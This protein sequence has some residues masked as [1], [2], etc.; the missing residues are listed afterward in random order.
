MVKKEIRFSFEKQ[1]YSFIEGE[2]IDDGKKFLNKDKFKE[3]K[4]L[5]EAIVNKDG[6]K[7][8]SKDEY[9]LI[10]QLQTIFSNQGENQGVS[11]KI[12]DDADFE[13][14][15]TFKKGQDVEKFLKEK[16]KA[17]NLEWE[18]GKKIENNVG[19]NNATT[20]STSAEQ[21]ADTQ[22]VTPVSEKVLQ[23]TA[24]KQEKINK[25]IEA[26]QQKQQQSGNFKKYIESLIT[27]N[28]YNKEG[29]GFDTKHK[30]EKG[31]N[32]YNIAK[33]ALKKEAEAKGETTEP[34]KQ[35][36]NERIAQIVAANKGKIKDINNIQV[37]TEI[38]IGKSGTPTPSADKEEAVETP[39]VKTPVVG[40]EQVVVEQQEITETV[41][42]GNKPKADPSTEDWSVVA[43]YQGT[44]GVK[45]YTQ[46]KGTGEEAKTETKFVYEK[47]GIK[48]EGA[49]ETAV[50]AQA[51]K[52]NKALTA[53]ATA[54][55]SE[56]AEAKT[57]RIQEALATILE[58]GT[59]SAV[60]TGLTK[61][62]ENKA[63]VSKEYYQN[64][65]INML[66][67]GDPNLVE[68]MLGED[69]ETLETL[70]NDNPE[71]QKHIGSMIKELNQ[72]YENSTITL[73]EQKIRDVLKNN[74]ID[75]DGVTIAEQDAVTAQ[76]ATESAPAVEA[77]DKVF[78]KT[79]ITDNEG[80]SYYKATLG[81]EGDLKDVEFRA[82]D[83]KDLNDFL[84][85]LEKA[86]DDNA[87]TALFKE[88]AENCNDSDLL[89]CLA[90][91]ADKL[92]ADKADIK[93]LVENATLDTLYALNLPE[94]GEAK[95]DVQNVIKA[96][97]EAIQN[98][99][100]LRALP[101][102]AKYFDKISEVNIKDRKTELMKSTDI[103][104]YQVT[105]VTVNTEEKDQNDNIVT[106][107]L[108][109]YTKEGQADV[110]TVILMNPIT[111]EDTE[112]SVASQEE[113][114]KL[115]KDIDELALVKP[116]AETPLND[117]QKKE[118]LEK[119]VKYSEVR[120]T[121]EAYADIAIALKDNTLVNKDTPEAKAL[122]QKLLLTR[123]AGVVEAL[124]KKDD[125]VDNTLF[126]NDPVALKTLA[127]IFKE[128]RDLENAG[129]NLGKDLSAQNEI[130]TN[131]P[132]LMP[133]ID[134]YKGKD[135][136]ALKD[137]ID[138]NFDAN[139]I[140]EASLD[141][142]N[143]LRFDGEGNLAVYGDNG[144]VT[145]NKVL[146]GV[147]ISK[148]PRSKVLDDPIL[149]KDNAAL[150]TLI[151]TNK[152]VEFSKDDLIKLINLDT[153]DAELL[154]YIDFENLNS[155][156]SDDD[157][158]AVQE[159]YM[160]K[161][162]ALF[163]FE[164]KEGEK[165]N[166]ANARY[167]DEIITQ[168]NS[169]HTE[170]TVDGK[171][172]D[173]DHAVIQGI[174][175][176]FFTTTGDASNQIT[177]LKDFRRFTYEEMAGLADVVAN[178]GFM[179]Q[180][181][182]LAKTITIEDMQYG[183]Y[184]R[185]IE[186]NNLNVAVHNK[187]TEIVKNM[188]SEQ[189]VLGFI[190]KIEYKNYH[191]PFDKI[192]EK[193]PKSEAIRVKILENLS[194]NNI[195]SDDTRKTLVGSLIEKDDVKL[196][197]GFNN[198][199]KLQYLL[200][201]EKAATT[202]ENPSSA[203][204]MDENEKKLFNHILSNT[205]TIST[206]KALYNKASQTAEL[207]TDVENRVVELANKENLQNILGSFKNN[208]TIMRGIVLKENSDLKEAEDTLRAQVICALDDEK[209]SAEEFAQIKT[210]W[211]T[212]VM[213]TFGDYTDRSYAFGEMDKLV[214]YV[215]DKLRIKSKDD[216]IR[217]TGEVDGEAKAKKIA[218]DLDD[219]KWG[220]STTIDKLKQINEH[221][222]V[223]LLESWSKNNNIGIIE[224]MDSEWDGPTVAQMEAIP[225]AL[226]KVAQNAG[227]ESTPPTDP[228]NTNDKGSALYQLE[229]FL[230]DASRV[231]DGDDP[232]ENDYESGKAKKLD[233]LIAAVLAELKNN[234]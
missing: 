73:D 132:E 190:E 217:F 39:A 209:F 208:K 79:M 33:E 21:Q 70:V 13:W 40:T 88:F 128:I 105:T 151:K 140:I 35:Q 176:N 131:Y 135:I 94:L 6:D 155:E 104:D 89:K 184:V 20:A 84:V 111:G 81:G 183:Q 10:Q 32:L 232:T 124:V 221:N 231:E 171:T 87:K 173:A 102:N 91:N 26:E 2:K 14:A 85:K 197:D 224:T 17:L 120:N 193:F 125:N 95:T 212:E 106:I 123:D 28:N 165:L 185:A 211:L 43:D 203:V 27:K 144:A 18:T 53:L 181:Q 169:M 177:A 134:A 41:F 119:L 57:K 202:G 215:N 62:L 182:A 46:T 149:S 172:T 234:Q 188:T 143:W 210:N 222:V 101:E 115:K 59:N 48:F 98:D 156:L 36:I 229:Q 146:D 199:D 180:K 158:K 4:P 56:T 213:T 166:P 191:L 161:A 3:L 121:A 178:Y 226:V 5:F 153:V 52:V 60:T 141:N 23:A 230:D 159:A 179:E 216:V 109:K 145:G 138:D 148:E 225:N 44:E 76:A 12:L 34:T 49:D 194:S 50:K 196:P 227:L 78:A 96:R 147:Y 42:A 90:Q 154:S 71:I 16:F 25:A 61:L 198:I 189:E 233:D 45:K 137:A 117:E 86:T 107:E 127:A 186:E 170:A 133:L 108:T 93:A 69:G 113:V 99:E 187:Y 83:E 100:N 192:V 11:G 152:L 37:G 47:E 8:I 66:K 64:T 200:P 163:T 112:Y 38:V 164:Q 150:A 31:D 204:T 218:S 72:K 126:E 114:L 1:T 68:K 205:K 22:T 9:H 142:N 77:K 139:Y 214:W 75:E 82:K 130:L 174:L 168:I 175:S 55:E 122:V 92:K 65:I 195:M 54:P 15:K 160:N 157:K 7:K 19:V 201:R 80:N 136:L 129:I 162:K 51:E 29:L 67:T 167:L 24:E 207:R 30:I 228:D 110:Y 74:A 118:N 58:V 223:A 63:N 103:S 206:I 116:T 220:S 219:N 97:F